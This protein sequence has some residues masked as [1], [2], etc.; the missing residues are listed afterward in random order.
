M[1]EFVNLYLGHA[2]PG[3]SNVLVE[4]YGVLRIS[5]CDPD[6]ER[7]HRVS[8]EVDGVDEK[9]HWFQTSGAFSPNNI[10]NSLVLFRIRSAPNC[11]SSSSSPKPHKTPNV[12]VPA[13]LPARISTVV[14]PIMRH[15]GGLTPIFC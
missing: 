15:S 14:S 4:R 6:L 3:H 2:C 7:S 8:F 5:G 13:A 9:L 11:L 10:A 1:E 12:C